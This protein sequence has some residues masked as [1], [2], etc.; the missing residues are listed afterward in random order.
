MSDGLYKEKGSRFIAIAR[1]VSSQEE[2]DAILLELKKQYHDARHHCYA[3][4]LGKEGKRFRTSD[5]GEPSHS[6]GDPILGQIRSR[7]LTDTLVVV[8]RYFGGT[9]L[10]VGGLMQAYRTAASDALDNNKTVHKTRKKTVTVYYGYEKTGPVM[11]LIEEAGGEIV[12][13]KFEASCTVQVLVRE[14]N[15]PRLL[16][17]LRLI[18][19]IRILEGDEDDPGFIGS[20]RSPRR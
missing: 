17:G 10:G 11:R 15:A 9:K 12:S 4:V 16:E 1:P 20:R 7:D 2:I 14:K 5:D 13:Q 8:I 3:W 19:G 18:D 6:A